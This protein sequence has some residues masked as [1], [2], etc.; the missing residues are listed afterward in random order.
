LRELHLKIN[1][2]NLS[3]EE[4]IGIL[5]S[6]CTL[7]KLEDFWFAIVPLSSDSKVFLSHAKQ[8]FENHRYLKYF[9]MGIP[10]S[11]MFLKL[12]ERVFEIQEVKNSL[13]IL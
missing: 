4:S 5:D 1:G 2:E 8:L 12:P 11:E 13:M 6:L 7:S 3:D 10:E 9:W